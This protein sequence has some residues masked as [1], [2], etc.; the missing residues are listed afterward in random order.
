MRVAVIGVNGQLG[1]DVC[2]AFSTTGHE[3]VPLNHYTVDIAYYA[4]V[5]A[6]LE[7]AK[8]DLIVNTAMHNVEACEDELAKSLSIWLVS[9][10]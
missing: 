2:A 1:C 5:S 10:H 9:A 6:Q 8:A 3:V 4:S 7:S